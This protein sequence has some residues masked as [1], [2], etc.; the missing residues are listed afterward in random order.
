[1]QKHISIFF[2]SPPT[3]PFWG[4]IP[5]EAETNGAEAVFPETMRSSSFTLSNGA[6]AT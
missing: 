1:M 3:Q 5:G 6:P 4:Y 2:L